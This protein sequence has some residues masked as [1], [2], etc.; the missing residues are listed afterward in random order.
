MGHY[1]K[2][3]PI[4]SRIRGLEEVKKVL[5]SLKRFSKDDVAKERLRIIEFYDKFGEK[6]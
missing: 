4:F 2:A 5:K 3:Y 6:T 1:A